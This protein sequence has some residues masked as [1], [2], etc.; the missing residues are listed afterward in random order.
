MKR[1]SRSPRA[2]FSLLVAGAA[3]LVIATFSSPVAAQSPWMARDGQHTL[4]LEFLRPSL[5]GINSEVFS[6]VFALS[7][8]GAVSSRVSVV[9]ELPFVRHES[10]LEDPFFPEEFSSNTIGNPYA[11]VELQLASGPAFLEFGVR[12][13]LAA[14]DEP[15]ATLTGIVSDLTRW[16]AFFPDA[17]SI[18]GAF[19]I[20][21][22]TPSKIAYR[23]R[24]SPALV[25]PTDNSSG[26]ETTLFAVYSFQI[27]YHGSIA[28]VGAGMS[29]RSEVTQEFT[30]SGNIGARSFSQFE[31]H[32]DFLPGQVRP[33]LDLRVPLGE[34]GTVVSMVFGASIT[35][36]R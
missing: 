17:F 23:L 18:V 20:R 34:L 11:G 33:G 32:A 8:R 14:D 6:G 21:E 2:C 16:E 4:M 28:R 29:G 22:V 24:V 19:N 31:L 26:D 5:E 3:L 30:G 27:G 7:G 12:P 1:R 35:W 9:G 15:A 25:I 36:T 13:P 10:T